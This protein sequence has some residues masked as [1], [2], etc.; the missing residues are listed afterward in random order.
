MNNY[1]KAVEEYLSKALQYGK[2][3]PNDKRKR[4]PQKKIKK[5]DLKKMIRVAQ[6]MIKDQ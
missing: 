3:G 1:L 6:K 4:Q 5:K 2:P